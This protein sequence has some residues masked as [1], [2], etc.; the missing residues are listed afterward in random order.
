VFLRNKQVLDAQ[1]GSMAD[2]PDEQKMQIRTLFAEDMIK[3]QFPNKTLE[4][5]SD[6]SRYF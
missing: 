2:I 6:Y 4:V 3:G 5:L 1:L